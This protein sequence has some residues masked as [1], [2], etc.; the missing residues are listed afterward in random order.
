MA[1]FYYCLTKIISLSDAIGRELIRL[2]HLP[3]ENSDFFDDA[4]LDVS[5]FSFESISASSFDWVPFFVDV[6]VEIVGFWL[7]LRLLFSSDIGW[8]IDSS[9]DSTSAMLDSS[10]SS[11]SLNEQIDMS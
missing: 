3:S 2:K 7:D 5:L 6:V 11:Q 9:L 4:W 8:A 1:T 10:L